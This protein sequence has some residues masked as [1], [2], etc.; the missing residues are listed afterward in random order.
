MAS[1]SEMLSL[2]ICAVSAMLWQS[3]CRSESSWTFPWQQNGGGQGTEKLQTFSLFHSTPKVINKPL[4]F[5]WF[6]KLFCTALFSLALPNSFEGYNSGFLQ[7]RQQL[8]HWYHDLMVSKY[9]S[10]NARTILV[11][12]WTAAT[13]VAKVPLAPPKT[14]VA[15]VK[16]LD[17]CLQSNQQASRLSQLVVGLSRFVMSWDCHKWT[18]SQNAITTHLQKKSRST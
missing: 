16:A 9:S 7:R 12:L 8:W 17:M 1:A 13:A 18:C 10:G 2:H 3:F 6:D 4:Q 15:W 14:A 11:A 5:L